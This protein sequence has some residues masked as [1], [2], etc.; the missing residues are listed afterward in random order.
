MSLTKEKRQLRTRA[1]TSGQ[2]KSFRYGLNNEIRH[3]IPKAI[4]KEKQLTDTPIVSLLAVSGNVAKVAAGV[5]LC[6][7]LDHARI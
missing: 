7:L 1:L 2:N 4:E 6:A 5:P 3:Q